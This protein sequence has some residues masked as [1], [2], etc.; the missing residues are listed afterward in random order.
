MLHGVIH[1]EHVLQR[2]PLISKLEHVLR[3]AIHTGSPH[4][5]C[6]NKRETKFVTTA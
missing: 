5:H 3:N 6:Q 4:L 2:V 1:L